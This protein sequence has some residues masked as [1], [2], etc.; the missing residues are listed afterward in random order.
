MH[1]KGAQV[2]SDSIRMHV[3]VQI[4]LFRSKRHSKGLTAV[5]MVMQVCY[6]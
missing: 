5:V 6:Y 2:L 1:H 4:V 3:L